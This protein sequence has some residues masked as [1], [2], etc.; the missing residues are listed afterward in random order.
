MY[1][2]KFNSVLVEIEVDQ[3][4]G[5]NDDSMLG[6]SFSKGKVVSFGE[7][8]ATKQHRVT[9]EE[10]SELVEPLIGKQII[11]NE[12][13]ESGTTWEED[14]KLYGFIYWN[15]IRGVKE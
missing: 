10:I 11:W 7:V 4:G 5:G 9:A 14:G 12:G 8:F 1:K 3:W 15:D 6:K 2:P 13:G